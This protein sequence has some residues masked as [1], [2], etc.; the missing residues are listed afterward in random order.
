MSFYKILPYRQKDDFD[1]KDDPN[2]KDNPNDKI[3]SQFLLYLL[4]KMTPLMSS[5]STTIILN[6]LEDWE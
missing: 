3:L 6:K 2:N 5:L 1:D 4:V